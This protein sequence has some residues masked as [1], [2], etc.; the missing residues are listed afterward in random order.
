M[1]CHAMHAACTCPH[2]YTCTVCPRHHARAHRP[3]P[4]IGFLPSCSC[5]CTQAQSACLCE[6]RLDCAACALS[7][8]LHA[9]IPE[10]MGDGWRFRRL[11]I[12]STPSSP[13]GRLHWKRPF[14]VCVVVATLR[15]EASTEMSS[16]GARL[17]SAHGASDG[18][19]SCTQGERRPSLQAQARMISLHLPMCMQV[20]ITPSTNKDGQQSRGGF[21]GRPECGW[22]A[23]RACACVLHVCEAGPPPAELAWVSKLLQF[24]CSTST[25]SAH[26]CDLSLI[27]TLGRAGL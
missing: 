15:A 7:S 1:L 18:D 12:T 24:V 6:R 14:G 2:A 26:W 13:T 3:C 25:L 21:E 22:G 27:P 5:S 8:A 4:C 16:D 19:T 10:V 20:A 17:P 9:H 23:A 11:H